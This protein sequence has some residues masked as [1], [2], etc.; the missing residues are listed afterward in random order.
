VFPVPAG[1]LSIGRDD[2]SG[3]VLDDGTV[4]RRH[5][6]VT[7]EA[8]EGF[9]RDLGSRNG[10]TIGAQAMKEGRLEPGAS[11]T[12]GRIACRFLVASP[13]PVAAAP[14]LSSPAP[15]GAS[16]PSPKR[17]DWRFLSFLGISGVIVLTVLWAWYSRTRDGSPPL[18]VLMKEGEERYVPV[19][20]LASPFEP[21]FRDPNALVEVL[22]LYPNAIAFRARAE[23]DAE[24][25][26]PHEGGERTL[27]KVMVRGRRREPPSLEIPPEAAT[28][29]PT[30]Q[31]F[32]E[33]QLAQ[34]KALAGDGHLLQALQVARGIEGQYRDVLPKPLVAVEARDQG[35]RWAKQRE[36]KLDKLEEER[37]FLSDK[38]DYD[39]VDRVLFQQRDLVESGS[40]AHQRLKFL[41]GIN[42]GHKPKKKVP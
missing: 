29:R 4:S 23:G 39:G 10:I 36:E 16:P 6:I 8:G 3:L 21:V 9:L 27:L 26:F 22:K 13:A 5:A 11:F 33:R 19:G 18:E 17:T 1:G 42:Q 25:E 14:S 30:L 38:C 2:S 32:C 40:A 7:A 35:D 12:V 28:D 37:K 34:A 15:A 31:A 24:I 20:P 41:L